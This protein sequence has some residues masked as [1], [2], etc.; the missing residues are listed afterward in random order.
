MNGKKLGWFHWKIIYIYLDRK[1][2]R[3]IPRYYHPNT[4]KDQKEKLIRG[5]VAKFTF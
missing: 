1:G 3:G 2:C 5:V 4:V